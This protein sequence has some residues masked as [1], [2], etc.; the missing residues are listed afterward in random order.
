MHRY[1]YAQANPATLIDPTGHAPCRQGAKCALANG[2]VGITAKDGTTTVRSGGTVVATNAPSNSTSNS[3]QTGTGNPPPMSTPDV[4]AVG[5]MP[6]PAPCSQ[7]QC[8]AQFANR[9][10]GGEG[11]AVAGLRFLMELC[12]GVPGYGAPCSAGNIGAYAYEGDYV[13]AGVEGILTLFGVKAIKSLAK[14]LDALGAAGRVAPLSP[15]AGKFSP[16]IVE[17]TGKVW[18][19]E[20]ATAQKIADLGIDDV[21]LHGR[22]AQGATDA[23]F[24]DKSWE[25]KALRSGSSNAVFKNIER[26]VAVGRRN[27]VID[28]QDVRLSPANLQ[29]GLEEATRKGLLQELDEL[30]VFTPGDYRPL[31]IKPGG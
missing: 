17:G 27:V 25:F 3:N 14:A 13:S 29:A 16:Q 19:S 21:T 15:I 30:W 24:L 9:G 20:R 31:V 22:L 6:G 8:P 10:F 4:G 2:N 7:A 18:P 26:A 28:A 23:R 12:S 5:P 11:N 1:L